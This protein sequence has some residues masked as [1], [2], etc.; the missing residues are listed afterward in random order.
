MTENDSDKPDYETYEVLDEMM[1]KYLKDC[2]GTFGHDISDAIP[3]M[4]AYLTARSVKRQE[5]LLNDMHN[6]SKAMGW[7]TLVMVGLTVAILVATY[8]N[9]QVSR[10]AASTPTIAQPVPR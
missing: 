1:M 3:R 6:Q 2:E 5:R 10:R 9:I 7:L 8:I 4:A